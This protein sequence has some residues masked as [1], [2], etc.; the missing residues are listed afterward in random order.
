MDTGFIRKQARFRLEHIG[1][2][3]VPSTISIGGGSSSAE[4]SCENCE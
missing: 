2:N 3:N 1:K 4:A